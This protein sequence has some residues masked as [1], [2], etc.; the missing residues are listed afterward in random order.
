MPLKQPRADWH[1]QETGIQNPWQ[2]PCMSSCLVAAQHAADLYRDLPGLTLLQ[3][4]ID[5]HAILIKAWENVWS[6]SES[7]KNHRGDDAGNIPICPSTAHEGEGVS[8]SVTIV[9]LSLPES[10]GGTWSE[11]GVDSFGGRTLMAVP[12]PTSS[13]MD[14]WDACRH[15]SS[16]KDR[17]F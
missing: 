5:R 4:G 10:A 11:W 12:M 7:R 14:T 2:A 3:K 1:P 8:T 17:I 16:L 9:S 15:K 6:S 13:I